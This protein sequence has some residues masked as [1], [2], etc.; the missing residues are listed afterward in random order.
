MKRIYNMTG[1]NFGRL[2]VVELSEERD[3][4]GARMWKCRCSC[5][6]IT[7]ASYSQ[8]ISGKKKSCGCLRKRYFPNEPIDPAPAPRFPPFT[9]CVS[10]RP[11]IN[12]GCTALKERLCEKKGECKFYKQKSGKVL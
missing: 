5:G 10:Y 11:D 2:T 9:D 6:S 3:Q 4:S 12:K 1:Q 7:Y 8:L